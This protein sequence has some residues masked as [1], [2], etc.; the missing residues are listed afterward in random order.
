MHCDIWTCFPRSKINWRACCSDSSNTAT[1]EGVNWRK[2][3][4]LWKVHE[5][6][7]RN[8]SIASEM[9]RICKRKKSDAVHV[10]F[11]FLH[12]LNNFNLLKS[13]FQ[14]ITNVLLRILQAWIINRNMDAGTEM[15]SNLPRTRTS[16]VI[17]WKI[18]R[19]HLSHWQWLTQCTASQNFTIL[20]LRTVKP[21]IIINSCK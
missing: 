12:V 16:P 20:N 13:A 1:E 6:Y 19:L 21:N 2:A 14:K 5:N 18:G 7:D 10:I 4:Q 9:P 11:G 15:C 8:L 17:R 3:D